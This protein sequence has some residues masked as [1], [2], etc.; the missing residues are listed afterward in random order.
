M[1]EKVYLGLQF[2]KNRSSLLQQA[3]EKEAGFVEGSGG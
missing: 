2:Q 1:E 3:S